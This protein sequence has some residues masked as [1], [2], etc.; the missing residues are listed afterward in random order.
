MKKIKNAYTLAEVFHPVRRLCKSAYTLAEVFH[1]AEQ[2]R[3]FAYTLA[4][5]IIVMLIIAIIVSV[6]IKISKT[7]L[8]S[9]VSLTYYSAYETL[10]AVSSEMLK[11]YR[12][13]E[14]FVAGTTNGETPT[15]PRSGE[16]FCKMFASYVNTQSMSDEEK[17]ICKGNDASDTSNFNTKEGGIEPDF[18]LRNGMKIFNVKKGPAEISDLENN[19]EGIKYNTADGAAEIDANKWGYTIYIDLNGDKGN[20]EL[21]DDVYKFYI[22]LSGKVIP[23]YNAE[24]DGGDNKFHLEASVRDETNEKWIRK[25]VSFREAACISEYVGL[26]SKYCLKDNTDEEIDDTPCAEE[27]VD[28]AL[29]I[30]KPLRLLK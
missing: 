28:C 27:G 9:I 5:V 6:T 19:T 26:T 11:D 12:N 17:N 1:P 25:S 4:E 7:K 13:I 29:K 15:M 21:W 24:G 3:K 2:A 18:V 16:N 10:R 23:A 20:G 8:D 14:D 30:I 22:P